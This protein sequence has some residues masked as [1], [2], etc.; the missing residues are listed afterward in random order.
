MQMGSLQAKLYSN[1][2][3]ITLAYEKGG[4][5][6]VLQIHKSKDNSICMLLP[7]QRIFFNKFFCYAS[8]ISPYHILW[9]YVPLHSLGKNSLCLCLLILYTSRAMSIHFSSQHKVA[10]IDK[11]TINLNQDFPTNYNKEHL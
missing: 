10:V 5:S 8:T 1:K 6:F 11:A 2:S 7:M 4:T 3:Y 9:R